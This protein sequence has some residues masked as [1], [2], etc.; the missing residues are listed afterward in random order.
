LFGAFFVR[1]GGWPGCAFWLGRVIWT[2]DFMGS[3][4]SVS[5]LLD[6]RQRDNLE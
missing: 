4:Y 2:S 1:A 5:G 6:L 3:A